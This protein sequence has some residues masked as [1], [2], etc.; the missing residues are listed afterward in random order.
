MKYVTMRRPT[1][2]D[3]ACRNLAICVI[4]RAVRD[5]SA[6]DASRADQDSARAFLSGSP[7]LDQ[8]C[9]VA[10]LNSSRMVARASRL[11]ARAGRFAPGR[12][13]ETLR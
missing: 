3:T 4:Q 6:A 9:E 13:S 7:M 2:L 8:W 11:V 12:L 5:L 10:N 1:G